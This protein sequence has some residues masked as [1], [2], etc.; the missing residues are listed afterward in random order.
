MYVFCVFMRSFLKTIFYIKKSY[1][2][3]DYYYIIMIT[4]G[5]NRLLII[6]IAVPGDRNV[7]S[8]E[9]EKQEKY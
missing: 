4:E 7:K 2:N 9:K 3:K 8:K 5:N 6:D 1:L